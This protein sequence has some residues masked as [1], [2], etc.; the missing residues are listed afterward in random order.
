MNCR[1]TTSTYC[2]PKIHPYGSSRT[3]L[4]SR[5][6][7]CKHINKSHDNDQQLLSSLTLSASCPP[8]FWRPIPRST[9]RQR[10]HV[11]PPKRQ[12]DIPPWVSLQLDDPVRSTLIYGETRGQKLQFR[13]R[14]V[15]YQWSAR[16]PHRHQG[17]G[18]IDS[19]RPL[20][21]DQMSIV[22]PDQTKKIVVSRYQP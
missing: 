8:R 17:L 2:G 15:W 12:D 13:P 1:V 22:P 21:N 9:H 19:H 7:N 5:T 4:L 18:L 3:A 16:H 14:R 10:L 20:W 11:R 6:R